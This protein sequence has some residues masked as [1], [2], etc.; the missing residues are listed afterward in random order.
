LPEVFERIAKMPQP[1]PD[2]VYVYYATLAL[3]AGDEAAAARVLNAIQSNQAAITELVAIVGAQR[4]IMNQQTGPATAALTDLRA[5]ISAENRPLALYWLGMGQLGRPDEQQRRNGAL[6]LLRIPALHGRESPE[7]AGAALFRVMEALSAAGDARGSVAI[8]R[9]LLER[10]GQTYFAAKLK[11]AP[12]KAGSA[13]TN[14]I[15]ESS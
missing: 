3:A 2:G 12:V 9:E 11:A 15:E 10:Y 13:V 6:E 1:R 5:G 14:G 8:R 4:E 7:L